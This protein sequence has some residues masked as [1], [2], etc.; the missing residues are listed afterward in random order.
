MEDKKKIILEGEL[1]DRK[2][3]PALGFRF[4]VTSIESPEGPSISDSMENIREG[5]KESYFQSISG[6]KAT[7]SPA[8]AFSGGMNKRQYKLP[9]A[10]TYGDLILTKGIIKGS[11]ELADWCR[12]FLLVER[13]KFKVKRRIINVMLLGED[14]DDILRVWSFYDCYPIELEVGAFNLDKSEI[15]IETLKLSYSYFSQDFNLK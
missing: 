11:S 3:Y 8:V 2:D 12:D 4:K 15:A 6:I 5:S 14:K 13:E 10:T 1:R 7:V 9:T